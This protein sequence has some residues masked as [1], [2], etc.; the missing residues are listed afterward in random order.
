MKAGRLIGGVV[1]MKEEPL[2][3]AAGL[4]LRIVEGRYCGRWAALGWEKRR[5]FPDRSFH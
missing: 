4:A 5:L 2:K 3:A 1:V